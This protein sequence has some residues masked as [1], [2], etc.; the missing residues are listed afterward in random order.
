MKQEIPRRSS[1]LPEP[2]P[3]RASPHQGPARSHSLP[4]LHESLQYSLSGLLQSPR[5]QQACVLQAS[6]P[7]PWAEQGASGAS[8]FL[9]SGTGTDYKHLVMET[10]C[11]DGHGVAAFVLLNLK[12]ARRMLPRARH[13][14]QTSKAGQAGPAAKG[15]VPGQ[16]CLAPAGQGSRKFRFRAQKPDI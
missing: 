14:T 15:R 13:P 3:A 11:L 4:Q 5:S 7:D 1:S 8:A 9:I 10:K 2:P 16:R 12:S 6:E